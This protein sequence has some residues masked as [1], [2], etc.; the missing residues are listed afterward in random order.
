[1]LRGA[2]ARDSLVSRSTTATAQPTRTGSESGPP[3]T[4]RAT[5][6]ANSSGGHQLGSMG[7]VTDVSSP[8]AGSWAGRDRCVVRVSDR[9]GDREAEP[10]AD[11]GDDTP[12]RASEGLDQGWYLLSADA[13]PCVGDLSN[14][15]PSACWRPTA[16]PRRSAWPRAHGQDRAYGNTVPTNGLAQP[17]ESDP[18]RARRCCCFV[19]HPGLWFELRLRSPSEPKRKSA[20]GHRRARQV[21]PVFVSPAVC[22]CC[23][24]VLEGISRAH[25]APLRWARPPRS[26]QGQRS[27]GG[28]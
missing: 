18:A 2:N 7:I 23:R 11:G 3:E 6:G 24:G 13:G 17:R 19:A 14:T 15:P 9:V 22:V 16:A 25:T 20:V 1:M 26:T 4:V 12:L 8:T 27:R 5:A 28:T 21:A 10:G